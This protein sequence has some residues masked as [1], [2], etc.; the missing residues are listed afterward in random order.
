MADAPEDLSAELDVYMHRAGLT[1]PPAL[2]EGL[3]VGFAELRGQVALLRNG[4]SAAAEP[5]NVFR[6]SRI[7]TL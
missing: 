4:R 1:V 5:S 3:L 7:P 6:L 2:R